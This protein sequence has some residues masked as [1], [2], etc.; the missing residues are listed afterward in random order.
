ML[1]ISVQALSQDKS[2]HL[3]LKL[4]GGEEGL[5]RLIEVPRVQKMGLA[6]LSPQKSVK[7]NRVLIL[8]QSELNYLKKLTDTKK[9]SLIDQIFQKDIS[10]FVVTRDLKVDELFIIKAKKYKVPLFSSSLLTSVFI[11]RV[12]RFLEYHLSSKTS[13]HGVLMD[14]L[15][16]GVLL[17]GKSG[18]GKSECALDLISKGQRLVSDDIIEVK[19]NL[20]ST[21]L[22]YAPDRLKHYMEVR[23]LG[24][25]NV[26]DL[27]GVSSIR[28]KK[29]IQIVVE[30]V[31]WNPD[32]EYDR[33]G[34]EDKY[35]RI[36][37]IPVPYLKIP[38]SPGRY[39]S[40]LVEVA[41]RNF[42][43][44]SQGVDSSKEFINKLDQDLSSIEEIEPL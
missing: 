12:T 18:I 4:L 1:K 26:R 9:E 11:N 25:I 8:G 37:D 32:Y 5:D 39:V 2:Y 43:L 34:F 33:L 16:V 38:V 35:Y 29:L 21:L 30:L 17:I 3:N 7:K 41:A 6:L 28:D 14:V 10:C 44:K 42:I 31:E 40:T 20:P 36:L 22:G 27:F 24:L 13:V 19:K 23:G 15:G